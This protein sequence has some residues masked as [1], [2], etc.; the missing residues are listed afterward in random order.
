MSNS[1]NEFDQKIPNSIKQLITPCASELVNAMMRSYSLSALM[2]GRWLVPFGAH[3]QPIGSYF[4]EGNLFEFS[5]VGPWYEA[6][7]TFR[8]SIQSGGPVLERKTLINCWF[9]F[10]IFDRSFLN[11]RGS[12]V[13]E[14]ELERLLKNSTFKWNF[15]RETNE[16]RY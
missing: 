6:K 11:F 5:D 12:D 15:G 3:R 1:K 2:S 10:R 14:F 13:D 4:L 16:L 7:A 9:D 8:L